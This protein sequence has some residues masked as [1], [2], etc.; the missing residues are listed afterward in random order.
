MTWLLLA[1][2]L[3]GDAWNFT[4]NSDSFAAHEQE[5]LLAQGELL[6]ASRLRLTARHDFATYWQWEAAYEAQW[7]Y[8]DNL[9][10]PRLPVTLRVD[11]LHTAVHEGEDQLLL[12]QLDRLRLTWSQGPWRLNLG[13]QPVGHGNGRFFNPSDLFAPLSPY[14]LNTQYKSGIDGLRLTRR[15]GERDELELLSF[16]PE[17]GD[18]VQ[19]LHLTTHLGAVDASFLA[20]QTYGEWTLGWDFAG[21][22]WDAA[23]YS[24]GLWRDAEHRA[25]PLRLMVGA[26]DRLGPRT[27]L[28][29]E[30]HH[31]NR[32]IE[33]AFDLL[34]RPEF[35]HGELY[36][37]RGDHLAAMVTQEV[38]PLVH[39]SATILGEFHDHSARYLLTLAWDL[40]QR[41]TL[42]AG[43]LHPQG[44]KTTEF[45]QTSPS[46]YAEYRLTL[47]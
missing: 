37:L 43:Y 44:A 45:G 32:P 26:T 15:L 46:A 31:Q 27:D 29:V 21:I 11:D 18:G 30:F 22:A 42:V 33:S 35:R 13:R 3:G 9:L 1:L 10:L 25:D 8:R 6:V 20:G 12:Q 19:L 24:E 40:S 36:L 34:T 41:S 16:Y 4:V 39:I 47:P 7:L 38:H 2:A 28:T 23:W 14:S 17:H 5:P